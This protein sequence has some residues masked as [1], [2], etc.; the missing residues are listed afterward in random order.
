[1]E[2]IKIIDKDEF[3]QLKEF[4]K[5]YEPHEVQFRDSK[6]ALSDEYEFTLGLPLRKE[7]ETLRA[8]IKG[9]SESL[10]DEFQRGLIYGKNETEG[11]VGIEL[12]NDTILL[13][14]QD[15]SVK[16]IPAEYW[17]L[18]RSKRRGFS[19][20]DGHLDYKYIKRYYDY[21]TYK[22]KRNEMKYR[23]KAD[24][25]QVWDDIESQMIYHGI[26]MFKGCK[27]E[28][29]PVLAF[30]IETNGLLLNDNSQIF[31][32][33]NTFRK[34]GKIT[35]K[36]FRADEYDSPAKMIDAWCGW[37]RKIDPV[38]LT[39]HNIFGFDLPYLN[40]VAK[41]Y[42]TQLWLGVDGSKAVFSKKESKYRVDGNNDWHYRKC[43][44]YGRQIIDTQFLSVKYDIG[45]DFPNWSLKG[46][47]NHLGLEVEGRQFYDA[48]MIKDNWFDLHEREKI[49]KYAIHDGDDALSL[50][51]LMIPP[52][53][54]TANYVSRTLQA[55]HESATGGWINNILVRAYLQ[56]GHSIPKTTDISEIK[57][58]GGISY[59][60]PGIYRN[61]FKID[62]ISA[63]PNTVIQ[64]QV[65]PLKKD[66]KKYYYEITKFFFNER[67]KNKKLYKETKDEY[68]EGMQAA[69]K[70]LI[71]SIYGTSITKGLNFNDTDVGSF[72]TG[73]TRQVLKLS[74]NY[75]TS[76]PLEW[77]WREYKHKEVDEPYNDKLGRFDT[78]KEFI[79]NV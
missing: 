6:I 56:E 54:Y 25:Y 48:A 67:I 44:I 74:I 1:V 12:E 8:S 36:L 20:L 10:D 15:G 57:V 45:R 30:D 22:K 24:V 7:L 64:Y 2:Q 14:L 39:N 40:H 78:Y 73:M 19:K 72:I 13:F 58:A 29:I 18:I 68:Y 52:L 35:R 60:I 70:V 71:N 79:K 31:I 61:V 26:T 9:G 53:F 49:C 69:L 33:A 11:I 63:Y 3:N 28:D 66:P 4:M 27:V 75:M 62:L 65:H 34:E 21:D 38:I 23:F 37:V 47:I 5:E 41:L 16:T 51:D 55:I 59:G 77:H 43:K 46:I 17:F 42:G 76:Y 50:F 32:I